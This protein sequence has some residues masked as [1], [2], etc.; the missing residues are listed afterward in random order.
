MSDKKILDFFELSEEEKEQ[1]QDHDWTEH[2]HGMPDFVQKDKPPHKTVIVHFRDD[3]GYSDFQKRLE[4][5][6]T[7]KTKSLWHPKLEIDDN[8]LK[9]WIE[10]DE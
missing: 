8:T 10:E 6:L 9:R 3:E 1:F 4:Q 7:Y 5:D 2:W